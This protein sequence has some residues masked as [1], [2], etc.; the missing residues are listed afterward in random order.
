MLMPDEGPQTRAALTRRERWKIAYI[1]RRNAIFGSPPSNIGA[2]GCLS[3]KAS[4]RPARL[5]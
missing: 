2:R 1:A 4:Q 3:S 5:R